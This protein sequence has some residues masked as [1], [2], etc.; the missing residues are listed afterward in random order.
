MTATVTEGTAA[1][2]PVRRTSGRNWGLLLIE[3]VGTVIAHAQDVRASLREIVEL[4][5]DRLD[6]EVCSLY[7]YDAPHR[8]LVLAAT[9]GLDPGS[10]GKVTMRVDEGLTG[11]AIEKMEPVMAVDALAHPRYKYFPETGEERYH[12]FMGVPVIDKREPLGVLVVQ[13]SRRRRFTRDQIRLLKAITVPV[14]GLLVR[15][16]LQESLRTK[17]E[18]RRSAHDRMVEVTQRL[19]AYER[20]DAPVRAPG[21][22]GRLSGLGASPGFGIGRA[23]LLT[24]VVSFAELPPRRR[25]SAKRELTRLRGAID[26]SIEEIARL[27]RRVAVTLPEF[28]AAI[29]E[30][31]GMLLCDSHLIARL[32]ALIHAGDSAEHALEQVIGHMVAEF[33]RL[34]DAY[35]RD[36]VTDIKDIGQRVLRN[37]LGVTERHTPAT[38]TFVVV[39]HELTLSDLSML[40]QQGLKGIVLATGGV[41]SHASILAKSLEIATVVGVGH[42]AETVREGDQLIVDGNAGTVYVNPAPDI[43]REYERL[44]REYRAFNRELETLRELPAMT[45]DGHQ[46]A[47]TA[48]VGLLGDLVLALHHGAEGVGLYRTEIPFMSHRD[49]LTEDEQV[50]LYR[51]MLQRLEG[52]PIAIR[53][54]DMGAD[55]YPSYLRL[56]REDN[57]FLGWRSIRISLEMPEIFSVQLRAILRASAYGDVRILFPMISG[58]EEI[59]RVKELLGQAQDDVRREGHA[60]NENMAIGVMIEVPSAVRLAPLLSQEVDFL[61]IGTNDLIQYLLAV[62]RNNPKVAPLYEPLHP[63]VLRAIADTVAAAKAAGKRVT[64]CGEMAADPACTLMLI[65]LG[66]DGLSMGPFF[67]P[68]IKRLIRSV[69]LSRARQLAAELLTLSTVKEIKGCLFEGMRSLGV[70]DFMDMYH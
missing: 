59:R 35:M 22:P 43:V 8:Q 39:A 32:E 21:A 28:D 6:M 50:E 12:S 42:L 54:L 49:F 41:T 40:E 45:R 60:F 30:A 5:A 18:E 61:S 65:G 48:N 16:Q 2:R 27:G 1:K 67:I 44:G 58:L 11:Y 55:K 46:I 24:P 34:D 66:L 62:D 9:K 51:L 15:A 56:P 64:I 68:V 7:V 70:I 20:V 37:L 63:A 57:P 52:R 53:T 19:Q 10:V 47:L 36:R 3:D 31:Q 4:L 17:E 14:S 33:T 69:D 29:F 26:H 25:G 38:S 13:T 23:H